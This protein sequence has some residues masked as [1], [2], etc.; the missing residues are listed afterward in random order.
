MDIA[1]LSSASSL[2]AYVLKTRPNV[3]FSSDH[4]SNAQSSFITICQCPGNPEVPFPSV[5]GIN[6]KFTAT[7]SAGSYKLE[8]K[9]VII[10]Q[11]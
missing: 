3:P 2:A 7:T 4:I 11:L 10:D 1:G 9:K 5:L 8:N 6:Y